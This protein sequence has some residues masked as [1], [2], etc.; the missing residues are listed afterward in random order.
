MNSLAVLPDLDALR[1]GPD[2]PRPADAANGVNPAMQPRAGEVIDL[3]RPPFVAARVDRRAVD[4]D[5]PAERV[6]PAGH[7]KR[8]EIAPGLIF[9][10]VAV[11]DH[12]GEHARCAGERP[13]DHASLDPI[14]LHVRSAGQEDDLFGDPLQADRLDP[15]GQRLGGEAVERGLPR[16]AEGEVGEHLQLGGSAAFGLQEFLRELAPGGVRQKR[17]EGVEPIAAMVDDLRPPWPPAPVLDQSRLPAAPRSRRR[18]ADKSR[19]PAPARPSGHW[20]ISHNSS[21]NSPQC[22]QGIS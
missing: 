17:N 15:A 5:L 10:G 12:M 3:L 21:K 1:P 13:A 19:S 20:I 4:F 6:A 18:S 2:R 22:G 14:I 8:I 11:D 16:L 7:E 9:E